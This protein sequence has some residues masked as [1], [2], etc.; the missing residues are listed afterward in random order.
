MGRGVDDL[1][2]VS[3]LIPVVAALGTVVSV[4]IQPP[5][6]SGDATALPDWLDLVWGLV[7]AGIFCVLVVVVGTFGGNVPAKRRNARSAAELRVRLAELKDKLVTIDRAKNA[8]AGTKVLLSVT[9]IQDAHDF[10]ATALGLPLYSEPSSLQAVEP[11]DPPPDYPAL[12]DRLHE[13]EAAIIAVEPVTD[14]LGDAQY[15]HLRLTGSSIDNAAELQRDI[16]TA[17]AALVAAKQLSANAL[18]YVTSPAGVSEQ[19]S[20]RT[21]PAGSAANT[22]SAGPPTS[23]SPSSSA[24]K[25]TVSVVSST[26]SAGGSNAQSRGAPPISAAGK[27]GFV[28]S[29]QSRRS[30]CCVGGSSTSW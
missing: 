13:A 2:A 19:T 28:S 22:A 27:S 15:D 18:T 6:H 26:T 12:F 23:G 16:E 8:P 1:L 21:A 17:I 3:P 10:I 9:K 30:S 7:A 29:R 11:P 24:A 25:P 20:N 5:I 14:V 4:L